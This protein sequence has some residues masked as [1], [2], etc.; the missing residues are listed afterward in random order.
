MKISKILKTNDE[1]GINTFSCELFPPKKGEELPKSIEVVRGT[2]ALEPDFISITYGAAGTTASFT[3]ELA[4]EVERQNVTALAH[5]T[6]VSSDMK[7]LHEY[8]AFLKTRGVDNILALRGDM[9]EGR[10]PKTVFKYASDIAREIKSF[11][12]FCVGG[13]CYPEGHPESPSKEKDLEA[14]KIKSE[15]GCEF[16]TTQMF[17]DNTKLYEFAEK[18]RGIGVDTPIVCGIMP[19]LTVKQMARTVALSGGTAMPKELLDAAEKFENDPES[20]RAFGLDFATRQI[21][22]LLG[23]GFN[24]IHIYTMNRP[25]TAKALMSPFG[26]G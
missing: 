20:M 9:P 5:V 16:F 26:R 18:L 2:A 4:D 17:F 8:L 3:A 21:K 11:G 19:L 7:S 25:E 23:N 1:K 6:C 14:L 10:E 13:A 12:D 24:H 15:S 22:D